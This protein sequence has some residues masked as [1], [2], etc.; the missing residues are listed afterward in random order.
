[1]KNLGKIILLGLLLPTIMI[2]S[3]SVKLD[4][5][6]I[7]EGDMA[8]LIIEAE[9]LDI[10]F[11]DL[12]E[13][14]G[15]EVLDKT[16]TRSL[17]SLKGKVKKTLIRKYSFSPKKG[18]L[19]PALTIMIDGKKVQTKPL[20]FKIQS[21]EVA[22]NKAFEFSQTVDKHVVYVGEPVILRYTF[23]QRRDIDISEA[24]FNAPSFSGFW[25][26]TTKKVPNRVEGEYTIYE[27]HYILFPQKSGMLT[28]DSG[29]MDVA[30]VMQSKGDYFSF[31]QAKWKTFY[32]NDTNITVKELPAGV[33][34]YGDYTFSVVADKN[35][36]KANEPV[37]VTITIRGSGNVDA[38]DD[39][40]L[41][42]PHATVYADKSLKN[43]EIVN[44]KNVLIFKQKF[45]VV[46]DQNFTIPS[47]S[48]SFFNGKIKNLHSRKFP[49]EVKNT[50]HVKM[51]ATL[52]KKLKEPVNVEEKVVNSMRV[53]IM[54]TALFSFLMGILATVLFSIWKKRVKDKDAS[55]TMISRIKD[56][57][58]DK[59]LLALLLPFVDKTPKMHALVKDLEEN[60]YAGKSHVI[61]R[62]VLAKEFESYLKREKR[63]EILD[64]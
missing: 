48:F 8:S 51:A 37:N 45:A 64:V 7:L 38:I 44:G 27:I 22:G 31:Q 14:A 52:E 40:R 41:D 54:I 36:T 50:K 43:S 16:T 6:P 30:V 56:A 35:R 20:S 10:Q 60:I 23:K 47:L 25:A 18:G 32:S 61:D 42:V 62:K 11:P 58:E 34:L 24:N 21:D 53:P 2:A 17:I 33:D 63:D 59:A 1:M 4:K 12:K 19:I 9:G 15:Y 46:S 5:N 39:F 49:I 28:I 29:R 26:K 13:I 3:V 57:K 55:V